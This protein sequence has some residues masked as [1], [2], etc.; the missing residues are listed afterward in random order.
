VI[1]DLAAAGPSVRAG[2]HGLHSVSQARVWF[3]PKSRWGAV[4]GPS[5]A[6]HG[7]M[8]AVNPERSIYRCLTC[9]VAA[10]VPRPA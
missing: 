7:A 3:N 5:C 2:I 10:Y 8:N 1:L 4:Q 6:D 9:H